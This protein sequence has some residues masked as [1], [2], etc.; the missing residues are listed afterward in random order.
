MQV[1]LTRSELQNT[2]MR[3]QLEFKGIDVA[4]VALIEQ[5]QLKGSQDELKLFLLNQQIQHVI[6][7]SPSSVEFG[8]ESVL[9]HIQRNQLNGQIFA[10]GRGT[11]LILKARFSTVDEVVFPQVSAG[12]E[13][14]LNMVEMQNIDEQKFLIVTGAEGKPFLEKELL[15]RK[16]IVHRWECYERTKPNK[17]SEQLATV[18]D[19]NLNV[20]FLH[21]AHAARHLVEALSQNLL[22]GLSLPGEAIHAIVG[23]P[24]IEQELRQLNWEGVIHQAR[25][26]MP[27]DMLKC[28]EATL[29]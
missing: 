14:L 27:S 15:S 7:I 3:V 6:F 19:G 22:D 17:L 8:A 11:A 21:S 5:S 26:P 12:S 20:V 23:A 9:N 1:L 24:A 2:S 18:L 13:A 25:S 28:F 16:A 10:V 29:S 4:E